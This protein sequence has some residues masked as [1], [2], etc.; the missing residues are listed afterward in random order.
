MD[1]TMAYRIFVRLWYC[2]VASP[3]HPTKRPWHAPTLYA[4]DTAVATMY[5]F[6]VCLRYVSVEYKILCTHRI[7]I[8]LMSF[9]LVVWVVMTQPVPM[10]RALLAGGK[11]PTSCLV[12]YYEHMMATIVL[13][14][15]CCLEEEEY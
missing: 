8:P 10:F 13:L 2:G 11:T 6:C 4:T 5:T 3:T 12:L 9:S 14:E 15:L 7:T 1:V